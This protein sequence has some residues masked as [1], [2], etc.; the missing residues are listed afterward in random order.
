MAAM[1]EPFA[2]SELLVLSTGQAGNV[3]VERCMFFIT[4]SNPEKGNN[5]AGIL[6]EGISNPVSRKVIGI[7]IKHFYYV[8]M[9]FPLYAQETT[10][11]TRQG[12][13]LKNGLRLKR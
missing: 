9:L 3:A 13:R 6:K 10:D 2:L 11:C 5:H 8:L 4:N 1:G 7:I 12:R